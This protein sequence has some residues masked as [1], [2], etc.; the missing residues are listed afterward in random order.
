MCCLL[1]D[2]CDLH[3]PFAGTALLA[4]VT[5]CI[6]YFIPSAFCC[7]IQTVHAGGISRKGIGNSATG[8]IQLPCQRFFYIFKLLRLCFGKFLCGYIYWLFTNSVTC[9]LYG[10]NTY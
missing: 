8:E 3:R 2:R 5:I 6:V 10:I 9:T 1:I 7:C 4:P